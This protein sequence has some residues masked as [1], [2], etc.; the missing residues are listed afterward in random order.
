VGLREGAKVLS[1][2][3]VT[4]PYYLAV[5][6]K[7]N[8]VSQLSTEEIFILMQSAKAKRV[9]RYEEDSV[10]KVFPMPYKKAD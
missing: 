8:V 7:G 9:L 3:Y 1:A 2:S 6:V 5:V 4:V 10:V